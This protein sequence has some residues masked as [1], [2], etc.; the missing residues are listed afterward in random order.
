MGFCSH[1]SIPGISLKHLLK[2]ILTQ[3]STENQYKQ[4]IFFLTSSCM[5][6]CF[7]FHITKNI[8][9]FILTSIF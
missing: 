9:Q 3:I 7:K 2:I 8:T 1:D 6:Y 5:Y 4:L